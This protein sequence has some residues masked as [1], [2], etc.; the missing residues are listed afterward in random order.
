MLAGVVAEQ[1]FRVTSQ[2]HGIWCCQPMVRAFA[3]ILTLHLWCVSTVASVAVVMPSSWVT[4]RHSKATEITKYIEFSG[5]ESCIFTR[6]NLLFG[7]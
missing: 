1:P 6:L 4:P 7:V 5:V 3:G 2:R